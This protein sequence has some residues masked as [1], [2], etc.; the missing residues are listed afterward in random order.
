MLERLIDSVRANKSTWS[1]HIVIAAERG[2]NL[3]RENWDVQAKYPSMNI[4]V[5]IH[6]KGLPGER[7]GL[8]SN[9]HNAINYINKTLSID[10][11]KAIITKLDGNCFVTKT[12]LSQIESAWKPGD[13][14][15]VYQLLLEE[16]DPNSIE[17][18]VLPFA[19]KYGWAGYITR[20]MPYTNLFIPGGLG[21]ISSFCVP[22]RLVNEFGNWDPW[23][24]QEDTLTW[25]RAIVGSRE[26]PRFA[27]IR[28]AVFNAPPLTWYDTFKQLERAWGQGLCARA[29]F[30]SNMVES[31]CSKRSWYAIGGVVVDSFSRWAGLYYLVFFAQQVSGYYY[32]DWR[33]WTVFIVVGTI[34]SLVSSLHQVEVHAPT[35][36]AHGCYIFVLFWLLQ[37]PLNF[38]FTIFNLYIY[39]W[40]WF[41][42]ESCAT[43][44]TT[45][46]VVA[47]NKV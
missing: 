36:Y 19:L 27:F 20:M 29:A 37:V 2:S 10:L 8:G 40:S 16:I 23:L 41:T 24:I 14:N 28:S 44:H 33:V 4:H 17:Y 39:V 30:Y 11:N 45:G 18:T 42:L 35:S 38:L 25:Y 5:A 1:V 22:L 15:V 43:Y 12:V 31:G 46:V 13:D 9:I 6:E 32:L 3:V 34:S 47:A 26:T 7:P 21:L